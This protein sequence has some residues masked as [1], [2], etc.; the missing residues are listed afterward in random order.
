M[1][2]LRGRAAF[3][4]GQFE[5]AETEFRGALEI[6]PDSISALINLG[7]TLGR[8]DDVEGAIAM[9][10]KA[11][12]IA[13]ANSTALFNLGRLLQFQGRLEEALGHYR[14]AALYAPEDG[15]IRFQLAEALRLTG[16][17]QEALI[18]F[19]EAAR[20]EPPGELARFR[21]AQILNGL[22]RDAE[23]LQVLSEGLRVVPRSSM[24]SLTLA[25]LL[26]STSELELRDGERA[27]EILE[28]A[29]IRRS[30][31]SFETLAMAYAEVGDCDKA[32]DWQSQ[33][34]E[35]ALDF[36]DQTLAT[37]LQRSLERYQNERPC[38]YLDTA[39]AGGG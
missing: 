20:L 33:A 23:A 39:A 3:Q 29:P 18:H 38:R 30:L 12:E 32:V 7:T 34:L 2:L 26:S 36:D 35:A 15:G 10:Q 17:P 21:Q 27:L 16:N 14:N 37:E 9:F 6:Q 28:T 8:L 13:P 22:G 25:R 31:R 4:A 11:I 24:L 1:H 5:E 19:R